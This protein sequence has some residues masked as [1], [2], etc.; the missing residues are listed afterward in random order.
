MKKSLLSLL[1]CAGVS[2]SVYADQLPQNEHAKAG[3]SYEAIVVKLKP[4]KP[5]LKATSTSS[6]LGLNDLSLTID[7]M[8]YSTNLKSSGKE[9]S[10][11][12]ALND[13]YGFDRYVRIGV[14]VEKN[15]DTAYINNIISELE[16]NANIEFVYPESKPVSL[17]KIRQGKWGNKPVSK[18]TLQGTV[19]ASGLPD[20]RNLQDYL[21]SPAEK[22]RGYYLGGINRDSVN[23]YAGHAG[24]GVTIISMENNAWNTNHINLPAISL[25][26][27]NK[28]YGVDSEHDTASVGIIAAKDIGAGVRGISWKSTMGYASWMAN[29]LYNMIPFLK[30]GDVVQMGLQTYGGEITGTCKTECYVPVEYDQSY[31]DIIKALTDKGVYVIAAAGNGDINLDHSAFKGKFD[32]SQ[33]DSGSILAGAVCAKNGKKADFS[34]YGSR[35]T[36]AGWGCWDVVSTGYGDL[37]ATKNEEYT[38]TFAGT[39][40]ANPLVA[41]V[42]ASLSGI[43]KA[44]D[45]TVTPYQMRQILQETGTVLAAGD[46]SKIG[47]LPDMQQAVARIMALKSQDPQLAPTANAGADQ[48]VEASTDIA[49]SYVLDGSKSKNAVSWVWSISKGSGTFWLQEKQNGTWQTSVEGEHVYAVIPAN[50]EG[51][52]TYLLTTKNK[53]GVTAQDSVTIHVE[54]AKQDEATSAAAY[55]SKT[56]YASRCTSVSYNGKVWQNQWY[57]N[58]GQET[59]GTGG[60]WGAWR[61]EGSAS[62]SCK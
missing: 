33:R 23:G 37:R 26:K 1:V 56:V 58:A 28:T 48:T 25:S 10:E 8:F 29:N 13:R 61:L 16:Q 12:E 22:R 43:A 49:H 44:N 55:N 62:N 3:I 15:G 34:T 57:V 11:V 2:C 50:T 7:P 38:A 9:A 46:S 32:V 4:A 47:T 39:S 24:D 31:F 60:Q 42:V 36:S 51:D 59:P 27:G 14:P 45:I 17:D 40:S 30:A 5:L 20:Y 21:K 35:V 19:T 6:Q 18:S 53:N 54:K 41:G 52:V